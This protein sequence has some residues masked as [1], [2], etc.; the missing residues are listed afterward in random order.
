MGTNGY[1]KEDMMDDFWIAFIV[2]L[3]IGGMLFQF[4]LSSK[5]TKPKEK[6]SILDTEKW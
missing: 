4:V 1:S 3:A 5:P 6:L 2:G